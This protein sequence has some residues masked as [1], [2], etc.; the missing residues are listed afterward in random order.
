M[1]FQLWL[2]DTFER[3]FSTFVL[4]GLT[5]LAAGTQVDLS[6][7]HTLATAGLATVWVVVLNAI[8]SLS[9]WANPT[10][11]QDVLMRASKSFMQA[12]LA[13]V[14]AAGAGWISIDVWQGGL[15]AGITAAASVLKA[16]VAERTRTDTVTPA[17]FAKAA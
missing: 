2:K 10:P 1:T 7:A 3:A 8:P 12:C 14:I 16:F 6:F 15:I 5:L 9:L 11:L 13:I 4:F 17:S